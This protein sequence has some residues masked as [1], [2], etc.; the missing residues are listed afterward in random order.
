MCFMSYIWKR[1]PRCLCCSNLDWRERTPRSKGRFP[2]GGEVLDQ[3]TKIKETCHSFSNNSQEFHVCDSET[4]ELHGSGSTECRRVCRTSRSALEQTSTRVLVS[5]TSDKRLLTHHVYS[6]ISN[7]VASSS[8]EPLNQTEPFTPC[9]PVCLY[10]TTQ[11]DPEP[12][13]E[14]DAPTTRPSSGLL[15]NTLFRPRFCLT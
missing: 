6:T 1:H 12:A 11:H 13:P 7:A 14:H 8:Q 2:G 9:E 10:C 4:G 3:P 15:Q 5:H